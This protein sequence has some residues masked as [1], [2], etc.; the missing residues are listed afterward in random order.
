MKG[1]IMQNTKKQP[2]YAIP[3]LEVE[4]FEY[5]SKTLKNTNQELH[6]FKFGITV[7]RELGNLAVKL[8]LY[9]FLMVI[10]KIATNIQPKELTKWWK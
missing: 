2:G 8:V 6:Q 3:G 9:K 4:V 10:E 1:K 5:G 7:K